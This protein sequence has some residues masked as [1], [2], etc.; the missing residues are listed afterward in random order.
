MAMPVRREQRF[1]DRFSLVV[2]IPDGGL[3][4]GSIA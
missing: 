1:A 2:A 4:A 3:A